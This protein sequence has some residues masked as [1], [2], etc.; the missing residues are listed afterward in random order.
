MS[1][2]PFLRNA[3]IA[4][5]ITGI[6]APLIGSFVVVRRLSIIAD[7][8]AHVMLSGVALG[9]LLGSTSRVFAAVPPIYYGTA[10]ALVA[11]LLIERLRTMYRSY[12][13]LAVPIIMSAGVGLSIVLIG[14]ARGLNVDLVGLL[15]GNILSVTQADLLRIVVAALIVAVTI[16]LLYKELLYLSFDDEA[17]RL[18]GVPAKTI[19]FIFSAL[20]ALVISVS[21][22]IV[23]TLL[24]SAL[25]TLPVAAALRL[26]KSFR[27]LL[28]LGV[29]FAETSVLVGMAAAYTF[30]LATGGTIVLVAILILLAVLV[31]QKRLRA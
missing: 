1:A 14:L 21:M 11:A 27:A 3:L 2:Y 15:F 31:W 25:I 17:A 6:V 23:G 4:G 16:A 10:V 8:L 12:S 26:A 9:Y 30:D 18:S 20:I 29:V 24:I 22:Q 5:L 7:A 28:T 19:N 13:E